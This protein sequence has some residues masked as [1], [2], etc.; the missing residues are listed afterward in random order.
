MLIYIDNT[1]AEFLK[2][3]NLDRE[4]ISLI[5]DISNANRKGFCIASGDVNSIDALLQQE[6][7]D[8]G[9]L[10]QIRGNGT[11][12]K[13]LSKLVK[14]VFL[15]TSSKAAEKRK[16]PDFIEGKA[17]Q[18]FIEDAARVDFSQ[19]CCLVGED[20]NDCKFYS[21]IGQYFCRENKVR[22]FSAR[23]SDR[24]GG[25]GSTGRILYDCVKEQNVFALCITDRD[26]KYRPSERFEAPRDGG[27]YI[28]AKKSA[29]K[30]VEEN[31]G[32]KFCFFPLEVHEIK[33]LIPLCLLEK[34]PGKVCNTNGLETLKKLKVID[35]GTPALYYDLKTRMKPNADHAYTSYWNDICERLGGE[36]WETTYYVVGRG[37]LEN[38]VKYIDNN[39]ISAILLDD[40]LADIWNALGRELFTWGCVSAPTST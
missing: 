2:V 29:D 13:N 33:N 26:W 6:D 34:F 38:V 17:R 9:S 14:T 22:S 10:R 18:F 32:D 27:T 7:I 31:Y 25:G 24:H 36:S 35:D 3:S 20:L 39:G 4:Q 12:V 1:I 15:V 30:L 21:M 19:L 37:I 28:A 40:Y 5:N 11:E 16:L 23:F 8:R